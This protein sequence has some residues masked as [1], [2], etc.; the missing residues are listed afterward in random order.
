MFQAQS[1]NIGTILKKMKNILQN[2]S[3]LEFLEDGFCNVLRFQ[4]CTDNMY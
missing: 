1:T 2:I 4:L 3:E